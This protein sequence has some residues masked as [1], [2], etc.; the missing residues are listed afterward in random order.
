MNSIEETI[1]KAIESQL[2]AAGVDAGEGVCVAYSGGPDSTLLLSELQVFASRLGFRVYAVHVEHG[3]RPDRERM[4]EL[5]MVSAM[6]SR[7]CIPL[8]ILCLPPGFLHK[9]TRAAGGLEA[10]AREVRYDFFHRVARFTESRFI[11]TGHTKDDQ[12]ET[13]IMRFFQGTGPDGLT[14]IKPYDPPLLRPMLTISKE[15][16]YAYL[17]RKHM[18]YSI[19]ST[20]SS[21]DYLRNGIRHDIVPQVRKV[22]PGVDNA[23]QRLSEKMSAAQEVLQGLRV[24]AVQRTEGAQEASCPHDLFFKLPLYL[25]E[26]IIYT[27]YNEW[28]PGTHARLPYRFVQFIISSPVEKKHHTYGEGHGLIMEKVGPTLFWRKVVPMIKKSYLYMVKPGSLTIDDTLEILVHRVDTERTKQEGNRSVH[29]WSAA[30]HLPCVIRSPREGDR[31]GLKTGDKKVKDLIENRK[32]P[33]DWS[34]RTFIIE[35]RRGILA[36]VCAGKDVKYYTSCIVND[37][38]E[39]SVCYRIDFP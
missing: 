12:T 9:N 25:R 28:F 4:R 15:D 3:L 38:P 10:A 31:L 30:E 2:A 39:S 5:A 37:S 27:L 14:G 16:V 23:L 17:E 1:R 19:D 32:G 21:V 24:E 26:N 7:L 33:R 11:A 18:P 22:F 29:I 6:C 36:V 35:D 20:N 34:R 13:L 8:F